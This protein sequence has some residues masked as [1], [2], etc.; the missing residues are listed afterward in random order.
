M[1]VTP[2]ISE[3]SNGLRVV[4]SK[5]PLAQ[6]VSVNLFVG[7]G[8][9]GENDNQKGVAHFLEHM[10]FKGT[11]KR[12]SN[13]AVAEA[14]EGAGG[15][16]NAYTAKEMTCYWNHVPFDEIETAM[17]VLADMLQNS[18]LEAEEID[19]ERSV[20]QQEIKRAHDQPGAYVGELLGRAI[21]GEHAM[22]WPTAGT[23]ETV[24]ALQR[25]DFVDWIDAWYGAPNIVLSV[26]GNTEH[27]DVVRQAEAL[28]GGIRGH[29]PPAVAAVDDG[30]LPATRLEYDERDINQ[31]NLAIGM[32]A[33]Q[34]DD[35]DRYAL[36]IL[37][38]VL[39]R[40][41]SSRLFREV[42]E[43]RGLAYSVGSSA[44]RHSD[45]GMFVVS[46]GVSPEKL[47]EAVT[48]IFDEL[49]KM[50]E[51][52][53]GPEEMKKAIDY[54]VGSFRLS[55]ESSMALGQRAGESLLA[56]GEI[57]PVESVVEQ[58]RSVTAV[59]VKRVA[60]RVIARER[61][62]LAVVGPSIDESAL[63]GLLSG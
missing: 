39:G 8:A 35:P 13:I 51:E 45:T 58:L 6:G 9:R 41:M 11:P 23:E 1:S 10:V 40:G 5:V 27:E 17:D 43:R 25:Q 29:A 54:T 38:A 4:T 60:Q 26:A 15:V 3:L 49:E 61:A 56:L 21:Y 2:Q 63:A 31:S 55:L 14:I 30:V 32:P 24:G 62:A 57:E 18:L 53:V 19:R 20:V 22:G 42:R 48:V 52:E 37:N 7:A 12:P 50:R 46:A 36:M 47:S 34:R 59:D 28:L 44:S 16:L 33:I